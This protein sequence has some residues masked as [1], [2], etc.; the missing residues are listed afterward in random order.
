M[1]KKEGKIV[2]GFPGIGKS[3]YIKKDFI[4]GNWIDFESSNFNKNNPEWYKDYCSCI[5]DLTSQGYNVFCSTHAPV[6]KYLSE[7][8]NINIVFPD[9]KIEKEWVERLTRRYNENPSDKNMRAL[10]FGEQYLLEAIKF[11]KENY[12]NNTHINLVSLKTIDYQLED[13]LNNILGV[14]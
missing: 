6:I 13:V 9:E 14:K 10:K 5:I 2:C 11:L 1:N 8:K 7:L 4:I 12:E 3:T